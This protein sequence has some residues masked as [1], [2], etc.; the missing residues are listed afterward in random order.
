MKENSLNR[1][2]K[3]L[4]NGTEKIKKCIKNLTHQ[5]E[6]Y[7]SLKEI[8]IGPRLQQTDLKQVL[9]TDEFGATL[10]GHTV[11]VKDGYSKIITSSFFLQEYL[12][13]CYNNLN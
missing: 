11:G 12:F 6:N 9:F 8:K 10:D 2:L 5:A 3:N 1:H 4:K 7:S 13:S